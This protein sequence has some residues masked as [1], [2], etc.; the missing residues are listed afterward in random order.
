MPKLYHRASKSYVRRALGRNKEFFL[1]ALAN[2]KP[3]SLIQT[4][5]GFNERI[6]HVIWERRR[7]CWWDEEREDYRF[8]HANGWVMTNAT[9]LSE[10][11][12][13]DLRSC[14]WRPASRE[15]LERDY[16]AYVEDKDLH[17]E[18][19]KRLGWSTDADR[20]RARERAALIR[21]GGHIY[22]QDGIPLERKADITPVNWSEHY[23]EQTLRQGWY[24]VSW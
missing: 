1:W 24:F 15:K 11:Y 19:D 9:I 7:V 21:S 2:L 3:G 18:E 14:C 5:M 22:D 16:V 6:K 8:S 13:H 23:D 20:D 17:W 4:C 12:Q 10:Y